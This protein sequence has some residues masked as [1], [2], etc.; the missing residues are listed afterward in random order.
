MGVKFL[1]IASTQPPPPN[2]LPPGE[3][4]LLRPTFC[5][6]S[7]GHDIRKKSSIVAQV[8]GLWT[9]R[10]RLLPFSS[11]QFQIAHRAEMDGLH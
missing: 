4:E 11:Q 6:V 2:P 9:R 10:Y 1:G 7:V 5:K 8:P 3:G